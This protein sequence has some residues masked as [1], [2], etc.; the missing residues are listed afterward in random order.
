MSAERNVAKGDQMRLLSLGDEK[1]EAARAVDDAQRDFDQK[2]AASASAYDIKP[3]ADS[4]VTA[5][6]SG[7]PR[8][9]YSAFAVFGL[10]IL[11]AMA[12]MLSNRAYQPLP[13]PPD[14]Q[15]DPGAGNPRNRPKDPTPNGF[16]TT[17]NDEEAKWA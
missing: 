13:A 5:A 11:F 17:E 16:P 8:W 9:N 7:D 3:F 6:A 4:D 12:T 14:R 10:A 15:D 2:Q 1:I